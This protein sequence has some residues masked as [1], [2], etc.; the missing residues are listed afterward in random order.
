MRPIT[1]I[2]P[3][4]IKNIGKKPGRNRGDLNQYARRQNSHLIQRLNQV[5]G[6]V[7]LLIAVILFATANSIIR[8]LTQI[9]HFNH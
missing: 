7:Y 4:N 9:V 5:P 1:M 8:K 6:Q 2:L 3:S